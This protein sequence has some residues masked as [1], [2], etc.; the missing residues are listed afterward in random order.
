MMRHI[1][2]S[3]GP[4]SKGR[5]L[6]LPTA[7]RYS[8]KYAESLQGAMTSDIETQKDS[9]EIEVQQVDL[10]IDIEEIENS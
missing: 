2:L 8:P 5:V 1:G 3:R 6:I 9:E 7:A 10:W 4:D